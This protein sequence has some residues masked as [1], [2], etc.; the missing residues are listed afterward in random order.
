MAHGTPRS[1][2]EI[3]PFLTRIRRGRPPS[4]EMLADLAGRYA[5]IGGLSP[6]A[7]V[8][9][10][11]VNGLDR[12]LA[13]RAPGRFDVRFG[14]KH[15]APFVEDAAAS[16]AADGI[17]DVIGIVLTP[18][19]AGA[20]T[21][22]YLSRAASSLGSSSF[23]P[24]ER[25]FDA[26]GLATLWAARISDARRRLVRSKR[27]RVLFSAHSIPERAV[28]AGDGYPNEVTATAQLVSGTAA[29]AMFAAT[30][31]VAYQSAGMTPDP[32]LGPAL[33]DVL[34]ALPDDGVDG[35]VV[36]PVGF[37]ADHLEIL[38][39]LDID[40]RRVADD[41]GLE[42]ART[43]SLNAD[44]AFLAILADVVVEAADRAGTGR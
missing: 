12:E 9:A 44:P 20:G 16:F 25:W 2:S 6:L 24:V 21:G 39:D 41:A 37:V 14:A 28:G 23:V 33:N 35:V 36:C 40:A 5:A 32:W 31:S 11:Q 38:F 34:R 30:W 26:P 15:T 1:E 7:E 4:P 42:F 10:A 43:E 3:E 13:R 18:Q 29:G 19:H 22:E 8:T 27:I 17:A